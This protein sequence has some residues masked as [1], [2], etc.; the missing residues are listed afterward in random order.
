MDKDTSDVYGTE[1][2]IGW[3]EGA[4]SCE[5]VIHGRGGTEVETPRCR[6]GP[7]M[8]EFVRGGVVFERQRKRDGRSSLS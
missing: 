2:W 6:R 1:G 4:V 8:D 5:L 3:G 7:S